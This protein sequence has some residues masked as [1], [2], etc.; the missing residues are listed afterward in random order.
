MLLNLEAGFRCSRPLAL[1][2]TWVRQAGFI[3]LPSTV[4]DFVPPGSVKRNGVVRCLRLPAA[5]AASS[6]S[7]KTQIVAE[8]GSLLARALWKDTWGS[9]VADDEEG[10]KWWWDAEFLLEECE[11][12]KTVWEVGTLVV[13]KGN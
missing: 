6:P 2:P 12:F 10:E 8:V 5:T 3:P 1:L 11:Q 7:E 4:H 9:Y 13:V